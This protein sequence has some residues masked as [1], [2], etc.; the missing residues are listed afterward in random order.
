LAKSAICT[1]ICATAADP[2]SLTKSVKR[3]SLIQII[4]HFASPSSGHTLFGSFKDGLRTPTMIV[5]IP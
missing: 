1:C 3:N 2:P 4:A 5:L